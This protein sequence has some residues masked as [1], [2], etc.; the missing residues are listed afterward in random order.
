MGV[1]KPTS[2][3]EEGTEYAGATYD[4]T[5]PA[6]E[7]VNDLTAGERRTLIVTTGQDVDPGAPARMR[8]FHGQAGPTPTEDP[9]PKYMR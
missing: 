7:R 5:L 3:Q 6:K 4:N 9:P 1:R 8:H 2:K